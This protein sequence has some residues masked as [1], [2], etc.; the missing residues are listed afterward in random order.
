MRTS[1]SKKIFW[2]ELERAVAK[3]DS[4]F[5]CRGVYDP[6]AAGSWGLKTDN[7]GR[8]PRD[9]PHLADLAKS[10]NPQR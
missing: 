9:P 1:S 3:S 2:C 5:K 8:L 6:T 4:K 7:G 10:F